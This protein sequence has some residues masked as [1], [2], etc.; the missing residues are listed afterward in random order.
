MIAF[1]PPSNNVQPA[2]QD[3]KVIASIVSSHSRKPL[4]HGM[5]QTF[6]QSFVECNVADL[7]C[8]EMFAR[9]LVPHWTSWGNQVLHFQH[10]DWFDN[11]ERTICNN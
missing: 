9:N 8:L 10:T 3:P 2:K 6:Y 7:N 5:L 1:I 11:S 4:I